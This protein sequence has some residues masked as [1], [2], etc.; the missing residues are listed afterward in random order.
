MYGTTVHTASV[1]LQGRTGTRCTR[2]ARGRTEA[3]RPEATTPSPRFPGRGGPTPRF[4]GDGYV[5]LDSHR[6]RQEDLRR[7]NAAGLLVGLENP[8]PSTLLELVGALYR[9][10]RAAEL[11]ELREIMLLWAGW[12]G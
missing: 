6:V 10:L 12:R 8:L 11:R 4:A 7:D 2:P 1:R 3:L 5:L 9:R